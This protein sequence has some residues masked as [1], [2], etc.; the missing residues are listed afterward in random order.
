MIDETTDMHEH[1]HAIFEQ[2]WRAAIGAPLDVTSLYGHFTIDDALAVQLDILDRWCSRGESLGGWKVGLTS[3]ASRD[4]FG[5]G[6]RPFGHVLRNRIIDSDDELKFAYIKHCGVENELCF[7]MDRDLRGAAVTAA[8]ARV[9]VRG[10]APAFEVN[11]TRLTGKVDAPARVADNL[12]QWGI[13]V[14]P[15]TKPIP[16]DFDFDALEIMLRRDGVEVERVAAR[17][18]IDDHFESI[19]TLTRQLA[20]FNRGLKAGE[21]IITGSFT[22]QSVTGPSR[23]EGDFGPLGTVA[24]RFS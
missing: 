10:V 4:A 16:A 6:V 19:A 17:G 7:V 2:F 22:R 14:G 9:A 11:E 15:V 24:I 12:S 20:K 23:W 21:R 13:V 18:H 3:G 5:K 8:M 1:H